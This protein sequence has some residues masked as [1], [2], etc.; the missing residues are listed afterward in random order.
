M[1][2]L[3]ACDSPT[4][5]TT[6]FNK[7]PRVASFD[8]SLTKTNETMDISS[9]VVSPCTGE[10]I[11]YQGS[12]HVVAT[13]DATDNGFT[14]STHFNTQGISGVGLVTGTKYQ[15]IDAFNE[16]EQVVSG[17]GSADV[18]EHFRVVSEGTLDNFLVDLIYTF[19]F[20]PPAFS[21]QMKNARC[22]G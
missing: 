4:I 13:F 6:N 22:E 5:P 21:Y 16:D 3:A 10:P 15:I 12:A 19:T 2:G 1:I 17:N 18:S 20:P 8:N 7:S 9:V 14:L 11:A